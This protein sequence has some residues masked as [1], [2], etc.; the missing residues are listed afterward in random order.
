M[1]H[2]DLL[3]GPSHL[4][5]YLAN[6]SF[7][8][9]NLASGIPRRYSA[10]FGTPVRSLWLVTSSDLRC[11]LNISLHEFLRQELV[12]DVIDGRKQAPLCELVVNH[13]TLGIAPVTR[14]VSQE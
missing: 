14:H 9:L 3:L 1:H 7:L 12:G 6:L 10:R 11:D 5:W 8:R 4:S 2:V 13:P